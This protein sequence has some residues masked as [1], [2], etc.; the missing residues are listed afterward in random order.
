MERILKL[1][2]T[3]HFQGLQLHTQRRGSGGQRPPVRVTRLTED[4]YAAKPGDEL[5]EEFQSFARQLRRNIGQARDVATGPT[6]AHDKPGPDWIATNGHYDGK[7]FR[8]LASRIDRTGVTGD[9]DL[10]SKADQ[11]SREVREPRQVSFRGSALNNKV[12]SLDP[13]QLS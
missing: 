10:D 4:C 12:L 9:D 13:P 1:V 3:A 5:L 6:E 2:A 11:L 8:R 7:C